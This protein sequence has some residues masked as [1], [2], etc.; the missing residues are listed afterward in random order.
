MQNFL[1]EDSY[2]I[3]V[4]NKFS[5]NPTLKITDTKRRNDHVC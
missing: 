5:C 2:G 3:I 4:T 1:Q